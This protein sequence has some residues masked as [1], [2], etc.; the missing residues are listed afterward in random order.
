MKG[1]LKCSNYVGFLFALIH[2]AI[3]Y[4]TYQSA[5]Q[6]HAQYQLYW[7]PYAIMDFPMMIIFALLKLVGMNIN[8]IALISF[9]IFGTIMWYA[10]AYYISGKICKKMD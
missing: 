9:G 4:N 5:I 6:E 3:F 2:F 1:N 7:V 8:T 10:I